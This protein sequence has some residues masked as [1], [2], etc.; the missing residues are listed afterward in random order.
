VELLICMKFGHGELPLSPVNSVY[1]MIWYV[2]VWEE[3]KKGYVLQTVCL[4]FSNLSR[5]VSWPN[6]YLADH[7]LELGWD[8]TCDFLAFVVMEESPKIQEKAAVIDCK[9][10]S[11]II[12]ISFFSFSFYIGV[13]HIWY[14]MWCNLRFR[15]A[16]FFC[17]SWQGL[18]LP[19]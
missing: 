5:A 11:Q 18:G 7:L 12:S 9:N 8:R 3:T 15:G 1:N 4:T 17:C 10:L 13:V 14:D 19:Q 6:A 2:H 16:P